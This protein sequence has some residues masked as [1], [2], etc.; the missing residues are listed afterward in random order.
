MAIE[1][2]GFWLSLWGR[3]IDSSAI[4][5]LQTGEPR[6]FLPP[7]SFK[8]AKSTVD[9]RLIDEVYN[10]RSINIKLPG[11]CLP[12]ILYSVELSDSPDAA[13]TNHRHL[14]LPIGGINI[15]PDQ[16]NPGMV[17]TLR[18]PVA[19]LLLRQEKKCPE[20]Q[21][22][23]DEALIATSVPRF[24]ADGW[25]RRTFHYDDPAR[26]FQP[27]AIVY[28]DRLDAIVFVEEFNRQGDAIVT[29]RFSLR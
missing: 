15:N 11:D 2:Q 18:F 29:E 27:S 25:C 5:E 23:R 13:G 6:K 26:V 9:D 22:C 21:W 28:R 24:T 17:V 10:I 14:T 3:T 20:N 12:F 16:E 8:P 19:S 1:L 7:G 4:V